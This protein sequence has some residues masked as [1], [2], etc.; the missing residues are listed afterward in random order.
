MSNSAMLMSEPDDKCDRASYRRLKRY[1]TAVAH[2]NATVS[3]ERI[4][5]SHDIVYA[6]WPEQRRIGWA[7]IKGYAE[8]IEVMTRDDAPSDYRI[9]AIYCGS[10][11]AADALAEPR[12]ALS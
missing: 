11:A 10:K 1:F 7:V 4:I 8:L 12:P 2:A 3:P 5:A 9:S 6:L